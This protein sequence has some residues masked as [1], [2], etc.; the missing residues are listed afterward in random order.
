MKAAAAIIQS[1]GKILLAKRSNKLSEEPC[2]WE[3]VGGSVDQGETFEEAI[4]REAKEELGITIENLA[5]AL[6][7]KNAEGESQVVV[8]FASISGEPKVMENDS[9]DE[10]KWVSKDE[11]RNMD[12]EL[13]SFT[14]KDF[15][16]LGW[17]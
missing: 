11:L 17:I 14:R 4:T 12:M 8:F 3:N 5:I 9:C 15:E 6:E 2:K 1:E 10:L 7:Y 13:A 16:K